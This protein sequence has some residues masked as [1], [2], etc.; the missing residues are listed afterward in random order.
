[1]KIINIVINI[2]IENRKRWVSRGKDPSL[3]GRAGGKKGEHKK[4]Y[5]GIKKEKE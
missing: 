5:R 2:N 1:M 4:Q 3:K